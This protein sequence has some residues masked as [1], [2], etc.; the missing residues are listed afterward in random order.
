M[1]RDT[2]R[3]Q[4]WFCT[5]DATGVIVRIQALIDAKISNK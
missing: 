3:E 5:L 4:I 1:C 2:D